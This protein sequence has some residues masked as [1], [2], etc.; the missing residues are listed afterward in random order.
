MLHTARGKRDMP[1]ARGK[2]D[3][4]TRANRSKAVTSRHAELESLVQ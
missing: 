2:R 3:R 4:L 1:P